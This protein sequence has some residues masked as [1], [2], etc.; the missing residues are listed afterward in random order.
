MARKVGIIGMGN[1]GA[2]V[3]HQ[4]I[5]TG[6][7]D[8]LILF[9][10]REEKLQ[11]DALDFQDAM[12]NLGHFT[13]VRT[14]DFA[15]LKDADVVISALG[16]ISLSAKPPY[17]R[18]G[19]LK[20]NHD[21]F[22]VYGPKL[23]EMGFDEVL[24]V[25]TN[26]N[27]AIATIYQEK[28]GL[29]KEKVIGTGTLLDTARL[30]R[31]VG[32]FFDVDPRSVQGYALGEHGESQFTAWSTVKVL[33]QPITDLLA[34]QPDLNLDDLEEET[35]QGGY[36]VIFGKYYT[37]Y[38]IAAAACRLTAA[39]INDAHALLPVSNYREEYQ[40]YLS[41]PAVV[42]RQGI[43]KQVKLALTPEEEAKLQHSADEVKRKAHL[44]IG[45]DND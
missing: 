24:V 40:G 1:V 11:A 20:R 28:S 4:M 3:A 25:I 31:A 19:E 29:A 17:D 13:K 12:N 26:P 8:E 36:T 2:A 22:D 16:D 45:S 42:G 39:I 14:N 33:D 23:K 37:N 9:D 43:I 35:R 41:Y 30:H 10:E 18:F 34:D 21:Q 5:V 27:D 38:G 7:V 32:K 15:G 6:L 44:E